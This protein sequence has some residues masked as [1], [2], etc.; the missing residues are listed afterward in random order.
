M[1]CTYLTISTLFLI[2]PIFIFL[3][4][5]QKNKYEIILVSL[6]ITNVTISFIFWKDGNK[7]T[8]LHSFDSFFAKTSYLLFS[9]YILF[10][11]KL[12]RKV[13]LLSLFILGSTCFLFY[14]SNLKSQKNWC[15]QD[16]LFFH[17]IFHFLTSIGSSIAFL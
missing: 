16:H 4:Q 5:S 11:K 8:L 13:K 9:I 14:C 3:I 10:I 6:L 1:T 7:N 17:S 12:N 2:F 15:S